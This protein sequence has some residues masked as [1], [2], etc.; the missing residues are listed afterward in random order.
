MNMKN[1]TEEIV[2]IDDN[3]FGES[4]GKKKVD[5]M[6]RGANF[7]YYVTKSDA[8][9]DVTLLNSLIERVKLKR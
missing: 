7:S 4:D 3:C 9:S 5:V 2:N 6:C 8:N 1:G